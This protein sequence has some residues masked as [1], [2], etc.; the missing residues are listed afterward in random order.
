MEST[1][2]QVL[3]LLQARGSATVA[4]L[5]GEL[6]VGQAAVRR[7]LDHLRVDGLVDV[8]MER[9]GVGRPSFVFSPTERA[10]ERSPAGYPRLLSRL[11]SGLRGL[12][13]GQV[14]GRNGAQ[15]LSAVFEGVAE[16]VA[17]EHEG[18]VASR[19]LEGRVAE[20][21]RA[22]KRE[23][24]VDTWTRAGDGFHLSNS[25]CPYRQAARHNLGPCELDRRAIELLVGAP[26]RQ[27]SRI[28]DGRPACEYIV[29]DA[30]PRGRDGEEA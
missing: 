17:R 9:H 7:H 8:H 14:R 27:L 12:E 20:T 5:T 23:G 2:E 3:H 25:A 24:I 30:A 16:Q 29:V 6:G 22:L 10:E 15:L 18:E 11:Y 1:R 4:A 28:A 26:V 21:S 13:E 19:S